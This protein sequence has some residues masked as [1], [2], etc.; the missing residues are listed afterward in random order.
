MDPNH[1]LE[2]IRR[3]IKEIQDPDW[4]MDFMTA[5]DLADSIESLDDWISNQKGFLPKDW[6]K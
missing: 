6:Q 2:I 4:D 1:A 5:V 3:L